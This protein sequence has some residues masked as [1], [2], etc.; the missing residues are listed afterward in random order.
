MVHGD[1]YD[2]CDLRGGLDNRFLD[3]S[4]SSRRRQAAVEEDRI[5]EDTLHGGYEPRLIHPVDNTGHSSTVF[6]GDVC[7]V[8]GDVRVSS[9][10]ELAVGS[11]W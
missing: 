1:P 5:T 7:P 2:L 3:Y 8:V 10:D 11:N 9:P 4:C 6:W